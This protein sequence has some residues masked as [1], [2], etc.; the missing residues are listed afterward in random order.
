MFSGK[1]HDL[2]EQQEL[3][4]QTTVASSEILS[5]RITKVYFQG[6][7]APKRAL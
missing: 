5:T 4:E 7:P 2:A 1:F 3:P 6:T